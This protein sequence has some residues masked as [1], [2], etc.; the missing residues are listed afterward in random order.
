MKSFTRHEFLLKWTQNYEGLLEEGLSMHQQ[1]V[2]IQE[3][4]KKLQE[5]KVDYKTLADNFSAEIGEDPPSPPIENIEYMFD[6][7]SHVHAHVD[8]NVAFCKER[9]KEFKEYLETAV[10]LGTLQSN[11][12]EFEQIRDIFGRLKSAT[13]NLSAFYQGHH[14]FYEKLLSLKNSAVEAEKQ[15]KEKEA[16]QLEEEKKERYRLSR[17][18]WITEMKKKGI[19]LNAEELSSIFDKEM[20]LASLQKGEIA[21]PG[22][23]IFYFYFVIAIINFFLAFFMLFDKD[24]AWPYL[25]LILVVGGLVSLY[26][27]SVGNHLHAINRNIIRLMRRGGSS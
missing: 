26:Y 17:E 16:K 7:L 25:S 1:L 2:Q 20:A 10:N 9:I 13:N 12:D 4:L 14:D 11:N 3:E 27:A 21:F 15:S 5:A 23:G 19:A 22:D 18:R 24:F 6:K 8:K